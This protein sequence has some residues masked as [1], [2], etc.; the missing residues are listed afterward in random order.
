MKRHRQDIGTTEMT[1][2]GGEV[3]EDFGEVGGRKRGWRTI[4]P[5]AA[6]TDL[7]PRAC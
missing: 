7:E 5:R 4:I 1:M 3:C 2:T 6:L